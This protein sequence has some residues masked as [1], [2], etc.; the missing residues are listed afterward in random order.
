[1]LRVIENAAISL[2]NSVEKKV[3]GQQGMV[4]CITRIIFRLLYENANNATFVLAM[5]LES[6]WD[7]DVCNRQM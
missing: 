5:P 6:N 7:N 2:T 4:R 3:P 1:M